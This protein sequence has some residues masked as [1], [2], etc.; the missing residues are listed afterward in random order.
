MTQETRQDLHL[1]K[2]LCVVSAASVK[3]MLRHR[4]PDVLAVYLFLYYT[5]K[6][7]RTNQPKCTVGFLMKGLNM[8]KERVSRPKKDLAELGLIENIRRLDP[9]TKRTAGWYV[10]LN[11]IYRQQTVEDVLKTEEFSRRLEIRP[12]ML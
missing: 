12:Q 3:A 4:N 11:H 5:A 8:C 10:R 7:Q 6:R 2:L 1:E 9:G